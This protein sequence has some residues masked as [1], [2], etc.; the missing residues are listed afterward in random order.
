MA[1]PDTRRWALRDADGAVRN[2]N[3]PTAMLAQWAG[4][5]AI[6]P[7]FTISA[8]GETWVPAETLPELAMTWFV[9]AAGRAPYGPLA[10]A[11]AERLL[12][13]GRF[14][15]G[16]MLSRDP[17][18]QPVGTDLPLTVE[19]VGE[20]HDQELEATRQR[21]VLLE[22][23]LRQ[24]DRR[25]DELRREAEARQGELALDG[26]TDAEALARQLEGLRLEHTHLQ[27]ASQEAAEAAAARERELRQRI[28]SLETALATAKEEASAEA[29]A[30]DEALFAVLA[31]EAEALRR[32]QEDE[33]RLVERL[34]DLSRQRS[35]Q[36]SDRIAEIRRLTGESPEAMRAGALRGVAPR[37]A[38]R[39]EDL[40]R[41]DALEQALEAAR[42]RETELQKR[43]VA[44]EGRETQL[45]AQLGQA[46]RQTLDSLRLDETLRETVQAL[47]RERAAR[48][49]EHAENARVQEQLLRRIEEL[50]R[51]LPVGAGV[52][53][54]E[55][56]AE[57]APPPRGTF[58]W[59]RKR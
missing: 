46:E 29:G 51:A 2:T 45:R 48:E 54:V 5:G 14:P 18:A 10:K 6:L 8:D 22:R 11:A 40:A 59:L 55:E 49:A 56:A 25:I 20:A 33:E 44:L 35:A 41:V 3:V 43:L 19:G 23:E 30:P 42:G 4:Q 50:E 1:E 31:H 28:A 58:G 12:A 16:A 36:F 52:P 17:D 38:V 26:A 15:K 39:R 37:P 13:E 53:R 32:A 24:K 34:R 57:P 27:A 7:G 47:E 9:V 21:L